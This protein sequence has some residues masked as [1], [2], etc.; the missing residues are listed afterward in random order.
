[1]HPQPDN[2][3][4]PQPYIANASAIALAGQINQVADQNGVPP[5]HVPIPIDGV[6]CALPL[7]GGRAMSSKTNGM[8]KCLMK[9][10]SE[11]HLIS[12]QEAT[13]DCELKVHRVDKE[14]IDVETRAETTFTKLTV[15]KD[16]EL[17]LAGVTSRV[18]MLSKVQLEKGKKEEPTY[19]FSF[20]GVPHLDIKFWNSV[21]TIDLSALTALP[22]SYKAVRDAI[23]KGD[24]VDGFDRPLR[25]YL[26]PYSPFNPEHPGG[27][28]KGRETIALHIVN[29][30]TWP[31]LGKGPIRNSVYLKDI[32]QVCFGELLIGPEFRRFTLV[33]F[34]FG[35][36]SGGTASG[37]S[38]EENGERTGGKSF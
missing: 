16:R 12:F 2:F 27:E 31:E 7:N 24:K 32:G 30:L 15:G 20:D 28:D 23:E 29:A 34:E 26:L 21:P 38:T 18:K 13:A 14:H 10:G 1:M 5:A 19:N 37:G 36:P 9:D 33:R 11:L 22:A 4:L 6:S 8:T 17:V 35:C 25:Q 3:T